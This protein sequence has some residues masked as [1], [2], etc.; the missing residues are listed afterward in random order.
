M[1][2][3]SEKKDTSLSVNAEMSDDELVFD[4]DITPQTIAIGCLDG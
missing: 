2:Y 4:K 1:I 3:K